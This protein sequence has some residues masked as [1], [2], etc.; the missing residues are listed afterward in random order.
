M[1]WIVFCFVITFLI[2][3]HHHSWT[4]TFSLQEDI[5]VLTG[6]TTKTPT[7]QKSTYSSKKPIIVSPN[8][9]SVQH[10][11]QENIHLLDYIMNKKSNDYQVVKSMIDWW[12]PEASRWAT[13]TSKQYRKALVPKPNIS[14][15]D[16]KEKPYQRVQ[17]QMDQCDCKR[18]IFAKEDV[19]TK[20][21]TS[22][23]SHQSIVRGSNQKVVAFSFYGNPNST[24]VQ[25]RKYF[26]GIKANLNQMPM[27]YPGWVLRL[28]YDLPKDHFLMTELCDLVCHDLNIDLCYVQ[29]IPMLGNVSKVFPMNWRFFP[30]LDPQVSHLVS[31]DLDSLINDREVAAVQEWL[32]SDKAFHFMRDHP[33][34]GTEI[35]GSGWGVHISPL[36]R[37]Y[38][39]SAFIMAFKD[40]LFWAPRDAYGPDQE[41]FLK[42]YVHT[43]DLIYFDAANSFHEFFLDIIRPH[44]QY[45]T[46]MMTP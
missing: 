22:T 34:H 38:V 45:P 1:K 15:N 35:L 7:T 12:N 39:N 29:N 24:Q 17:V 16:Q 36:E 10:F 18:D 20:V 13:E 46:H 41:G 32:R 37:K 43:L 11:M 31:R 26:Q 5:Y 25:E 8:V 27:Y 42:R 4:D 40:P 21:S 33:A 19:D 23:C 3:V 44:L 28:Y 6:E 14:K 30:M 2:F 9:K